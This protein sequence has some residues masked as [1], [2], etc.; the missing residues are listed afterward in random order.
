MRCFI[1]ISWITLGLLSICLKKTEFFLPIC[2]A[3]RS[4]P[5]TLCHRW[6]GS[7]A[8]FTFLHGGV[9]VL[10]TITFWKCT[11]FSLSHHLST[12]HRVKNV[13]F[14]AEKAERKHFWSQVFIFTPEPLFCYADYLCCFSCFKLKSNLDTNLGLYNVA[15]WLNTEP[16]PLQTLRKAG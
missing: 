16:L 11:P 1:I 2:T 8:C 13:C 9:S 6:E 7:C 12:S 3:L 15:G 14:L 4:L 10:F 5:T